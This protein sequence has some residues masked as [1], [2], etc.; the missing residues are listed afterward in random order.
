MP[1][2]S[3]SNYNAKAEVVAAY[4]ICIKNWPTYLCAITCQT[5][6]CVTSRRAVMCELNLVCYS[7]VIE[8]FFNKNVQKAHFIKLSVIVGDH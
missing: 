8:Y 7:E 6:C 5:K 2:N 4:I 1:S 3:V